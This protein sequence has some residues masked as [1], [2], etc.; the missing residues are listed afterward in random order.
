MHHT[1]RTTQPQ[2]RAGQSL[3][4]FALTAPLLVAIVLGIVELGI[5]FSI[6]VGLTNSA[7]E[8]ARA[9]SVYRYPDETPLSTDYTA[10]NTIDAGRLGLFTSTLTETMNPIVAADPFT[11]TVA[12]LPAPGAEYT[13]PSGAS[14]AYDISNPLRSGDTISVTLEQNH[15]LF[16]GLFGP[17]DLLIQASGAARIEPGG[18][19]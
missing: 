3:V 7:R 17:S 4:E 10:V 9:A 11:V 12:Y 13:T 16:W 18:A 6:Y 14:A 8:A 5:V 15:R 1:H 2:V 19:Q